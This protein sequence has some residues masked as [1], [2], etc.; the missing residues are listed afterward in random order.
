MASIYSKKKNSLMEIM[1]EIQSDGTD[2]DV[3]GHEMYL[4]IH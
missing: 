4:L 3:C 2:S 1:T